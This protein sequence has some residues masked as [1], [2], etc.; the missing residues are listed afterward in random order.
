M[1]HCPACQRTYADDTLSYCLEDGSQLLSDRT[2]AN[3]LAATVIMPDPRLTVPEKQETFRTAPRPPQPYTA[4][5]PQQQQQAWPP[6]VAQQHS[7][8]VTT[9]PGR[10]ASVTSLI[11]AITAFVLLGFCIIAGAAKVEASLIGGIFLF[12]VVLALAG[13]ITGIVALSRSSRDTSERNARAMS[14]V[15]LVLNGLY[16]LITVVFLVLGAV[17]GSG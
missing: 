14:M 6:V 15:A 9:K 2:V 5:P 1:K 13:A 4:P 3:D 11:L 16:L 12:S 7:A 8:V 17:A 10:A